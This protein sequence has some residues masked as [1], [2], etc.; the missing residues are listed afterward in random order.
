MDEI[1][2]MSNFPVRKGYISKKAVVGR[3]FIISWFFILGFL[4]P[5]YYHGVVHSFG[6]FL[7]YNAVFSWGYALL[8]AVN[9][10]TTEAN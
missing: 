1:Y 3:V 5:A 4:V 9:H 8:F 2:Y 10:W 7:L 6:M